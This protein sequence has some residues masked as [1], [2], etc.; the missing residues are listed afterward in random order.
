MESHKGKPTREGELWT[1]RTLVY[2]KW[3]TGFRAAASWRWPPSL[4]PLWPRP[5]W[6]SLPPPW[7]RRHRRPPSA[8][9]AK[10]ATTDAQQQAP[11]DSYKVTQSV[12]KGQQTFDNQ[13]DANKYVEEKTSGYEDTADTKYTTSGT[14][15]QNETG[16]TDE[17]TQNA[18]SGSK[19]GFA[20][21]KDAE[22]WVKDQ[23]KGYKDTDG[24]TYTLHSS[25]QNNPTTEPDGDPVTTDMTKTTSQVFDSKA[26]AEAALQKDKDADP[27]TD[28]HKVSF[29]DVQE[30]TTVVTPESTE[31]V[32]YPGK[33][34]SSAQDRDAARDAAIK[35]FEA[36]GWKVVATTSEKDPPATIGGCFIKLKY[37]SPEYVITANTYV[38]ERMPPACVHVPRSAR[39]LGKRRLGNNRPRVKKGGGHLAPSHSF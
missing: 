4:Q 1:A 16:S 26:D 31:H 34:Y 36:K 18:H 6:Q 19:D 7:P 17:T 2:K 12:D 32:S 9:D 14:V 5:R 20:A 28:M 27:S 11:T 23:T 3:L 37:T 30:K 35:E 21:Q 38:I 39:L 22:D 25:Y 29:S 15:T 24:T 13:A 33:N 10:Q 8:D